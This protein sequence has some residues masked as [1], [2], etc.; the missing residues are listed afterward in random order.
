MS[1]ARPHRNEPVMKMI[2]EIWKTTFRPKR[3]PNLPT[4]TVATVSARRYAV[5]THDMCAAPPRSET[6]VGRAVPTIVWSRAARRTP[7]MIVPKTMLRL[8]PSRTGGTGSAGGAVGAGAFSL[9]VVTF[10]RS[11]WWG[12]CACGGGLVW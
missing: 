7:S 9:A 2:A 5:T 11:H 10:A 6:I 4:R 8:R 1:V 3:S 12:V